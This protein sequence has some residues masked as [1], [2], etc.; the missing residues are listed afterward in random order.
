MNR[1]EAVSTVALLIGG[2]MLGAEAFL[3]GCKS[4]ARTVNLRRKISRTWMKLQKRSY[5]PPKHQ[6]QKPLK[7]VNTCR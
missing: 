6:A 2:T 3:S 7:L 5:P 1:R 4:A